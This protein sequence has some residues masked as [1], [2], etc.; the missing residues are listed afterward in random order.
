VER[1]W[2]HGSKV[3]SRPGSA[4]AY[5]IIPFGSSTLAVVCDALG[6]GDVAAHAAALCVQAVYEAARSQADAPAEQILRA[7]F[8]A[9]NRAILEAARAHPQ[10][11]GT[12]AAMAM[13]WVDPDGQVTP[14]HIGDVR[15]YRV[16]AGQP[17]ELRTRDHT[18]VNLFVDADLLSA[19]DAANH[20][21]AHLLS[22]AVGVVQGLEVEIGETFRIA[23]GDVVLLLSDGAHE[24][25]AE[26][27][28]AD[29]PW[30]DVGEATGELLDLLDGQ[31]AA[32]VVAVA[33][34][35][36]AGGSVVA[37]A[38]PEPAP[39]V[40]SSGGAPS[41]APAPLAVATPSIA[42]PAS[43]AAPPSSAPPAPPAKAAS[44][45]APTLTGDEPSYVVFEDD[46]AQA[47]DLRARSR[48]V[49]AIVAAPQQIADEVRRR[50][51]VLAV[52]LG[53]ALLALAAAQL[54]KPGAPPPS[55]PAL[56][57]EPVAE[58]VPAPPPAPVEAPA[59][60]AP[61]I[62]PPPE[63]GPWRPSVFTAPPPRSASG[64]AATLASKSHQ[65]A[66]AVEEVARGL[67]SSVDHASLYD[68][69]WD[70]FAR[71]MQAP[72]LASRLTSL[73]DLTALLPLLQGDPAVRPA[74]PTDA[75]V[76]E[77]ARPAV[78]G[79][80]F[81][82]E[83]FGTSTSVDRFAEV[84]LDRRGPGAVADELGTDL[85]MEA[86]LARALARSAGRHPEAEGW[87][88][89]RVFVVAR[90]LQGPVGALVAAQRPDLHSAIQSTLGEATA[91][92]AETP[93]PPLVAAAVAAAGQAELPLA[94]PDKP[95]VAPVRRAPKEPTLDELAR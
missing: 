88:A 76:A 68:G 39:L 1:S 59:W 87:W 38:L 12:T 64:V 42:P 35:P 58:A 90:A 51:R 26:A 67:A 57:P 15:V 72:V 49:Q 24:V 60:W 50:Q 13:V 2:A 36:V 27:I 74:S 63:R 92:T 52:A 47:P 17:P 8:E 73:P 91:A 65:C 3:G 53:V 71:D 48:A 16:R 28:L 89:R 44:T 20:P 18:M 77:W 75:A 46:E 86:Q 30:T 80:E 55:A 69:A 14:A 70:C 29:V 41:A 84:M 56:P 32:T 34:G 66:Q 40:G 11:V 10:L 7:A 81:R 19:T 94:V 4:D 23:D 9:A 21:E 25:L 79:I 5:G 37:T 33:Q 45:P 83:R 22:R 6:G 61:E 43:P 85:L 95:V 93:L 82:L 54:L 78:D 62:P 31:D